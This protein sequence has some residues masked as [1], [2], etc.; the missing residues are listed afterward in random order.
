MTDVTGRSASGTSGHIGAHIARVTWPCSWLTALTEPAERSASAVMLNCGPPPLSYDAERQ[1]AIAIR[2][3]RAPAAGEV[4]LDE[5]K[6]E[7]VVAGR[8]RRVRREDRRLPDLL[9]RVVE[10]D[11]PA[12]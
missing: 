11:V 2:P 5:V 9:E 7:R 10:A 8:H 12:R 4:L 1:E 3:E 6:R